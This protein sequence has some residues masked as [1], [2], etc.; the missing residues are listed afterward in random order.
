MALTTQVLHIKNMVCPR[1]ISTVTR[2]LQKAGLEVNQVTLGEATV[3]LPK[4]YA[5]FNQVNSDLLQEGFELIADPEKQ[6]SEKIK[7]ILIDYLEHYQTNYEPVTTSSF[8]SEKTGIPYPQLSKIFSRQENI[9]IE[10]Y[11]IKLKIEKVKELLSY[12]Q[13]TLSEIAFNLKYSSVQHLSNQFKKVTGISV[14][15]YKHA[16]TPSRNSLDAL[17]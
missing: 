4:D 6:V 15:E 3:A 9:T 13:L 5:N 7:T 14:S 11:F 1:C 12:G 16:A 10:K 17:I 2:V 8:L